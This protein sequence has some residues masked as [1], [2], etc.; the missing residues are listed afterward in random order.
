MRKPLFFNQIARWQ[1]YCV[2]FTAAASLYAETA[3]NPADR[4]SSLKTRIDS[5]EVV[6]QTAKRQGLSIADLEQITVRLRDSVTLLKE[7]LQAQK[8]ATIRSSLPESAPHKKYLPATLSLI[9]KILITSGALTVFAFLVFLLFFI[10]TMARRKKTVTK[11]RRPE[12]NTINEKASAPGT[13]TA[14]VKAYAAQVK[15]QNI[16]VPHHTG[17]GSPLSA[18]AGSPE[19]NKP[20]V[21]H[22]PHTLDALVVKAANDG[23]D[24]KSISQR[25]HIGVDQVALILKMAKKK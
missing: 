21:Q 16:A 5:L 25:F 12:M 18:A 4:L 11:T 9:D 17:T 3:S 15:N 20:A 7:E 19:Q 24:V 1:Q 13:G 10:S 22:T 2:I 8:P 6:K 23:E 14:A